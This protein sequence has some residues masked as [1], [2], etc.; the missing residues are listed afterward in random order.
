MDGWQH[1]GAAAEAVFLSIRWKRT[2][3]F[4]FTGCD[5]SN[6]DIWTFG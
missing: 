5:Y 6:D 3:L 2:L 4:R 1:M